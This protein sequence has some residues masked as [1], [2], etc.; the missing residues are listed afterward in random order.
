MSDDDDTTAMLDLPLAKSNRGDIMDDK[1]ELHTDMNKEDLVAKMELLT[2]DPNLY[3]RK[4]MT[5]KMTRCGGGLSDED[6]KQEV[7]SK[8]DNMTLT[9]TVT[10]IEARTPGMLTTESLGSKMSIT[11]VNQVQKKTDQQNCSYCG[12]KGHGRRANFE[13]RKAM[14]PAHGQACTKCRRQ[15][16]FAAVCESVK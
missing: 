14:C 4:H 9:D 3:D 10:F 7:L 2:N 8:V 12:N 16:H 13:T 6:T 15:D 5:N 11:V 1:K